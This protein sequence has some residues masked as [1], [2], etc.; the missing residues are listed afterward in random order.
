[1]TTEIAEFKPFESQMA[2]FK[3]KY[4][5]VVYDLDDEKQEKQAR[6]DRYAIG[7]VISKLDDAHKKIKEPLKIQVDLIDGERKRIK[8][9][10]LDIQNK[11]KD[12]ITA[13]EDK[14]REHAEMLQDKV[15]RIVALGQFGEFENPTSTQLRERIAHLESIEVDDSYEIRKAD[16]ALA[17]IETNKLLN[18]LYD[19]QKQYED[20]QAELERLRQEKEE[21]DR[22]E[23]EEQI[24]K[25]AAEK[26]KR[27]AEEAAAKAKREA[28]EKTRR[29]RE[30]AERKA[31]A[32]QERIQAE[33]DRKVREA[34]E[35]A[36]KAAQVERDRI[37]AEEAEKKRLADIEAKKKEKQAHRAKIHKAAKASFIKEGFS[38]EDATRI[39]E[40]IKDGKINHVIIEY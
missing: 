24:R 10:L 36:E 17:Q 13:H 30:E 38:E 31:K 37:A 23:R 12:Q 33:A 25:E 2:E 9:E 40:L 28:E 15:D 4:D 16:A 14:I 32:E 22:K 7:K 39:V 34:K 21:R 35:A 5:G 27:E 19:K 26:A 6:S 18:A 20:E 1:M 29:E 8:D 3:K 11:I